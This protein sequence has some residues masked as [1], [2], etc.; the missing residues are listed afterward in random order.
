MCPVFVRGHD[1]RLIVL[2][3]R[4]RSL[5]TATLESAPCKENVLANR[6]ADDQRGTRR[7][8]RRERNCSQ[9]APGFGPGR[10]PRVPDHAQLPVELDVAS[11]LGAVQHVRRYRRQARQRGLEHQPRLA[12]VPHVLGDARKVLTPLVTDADDIRGLREERL[13][14]ARVAGLSVTPPTVQALPVMLRSREGAPQRQ[15]PFAAPGWRLEA[16][17]DQVRPARAP[18]DRA[19]L[20][21]RSLSWPREPPVSL[22]QFHPW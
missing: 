3:R 14:L 7:V 19:G 16:Y 20:R 12:R 4:V 18:G 22:P 13:L 17:A 6:H 11:T 8:Q 15:D 2:L 5:G 9:Y 1:V 21:S 10:C